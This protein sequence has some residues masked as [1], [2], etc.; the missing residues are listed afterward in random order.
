MLLMMLGLR[1][2]LRV[3]MLLL[4][5]LCM[6]AV[7]SM[8]LVSLMCLVRLVLS[9]LLLLLLV[10]LLAV[11]LMGLGSRIL[12]RRRVELVTARHIRLIRVCWAVLPYN[13]S[14]T[15]QPFVG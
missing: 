1:L 11:L 5:M 2:M 15:K 13:V 6:L 10:M 7:L 3:L 4:L 8:G 14:I 12:A 9:M